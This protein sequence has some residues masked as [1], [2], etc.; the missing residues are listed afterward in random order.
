MGAKRPFPTVLEPLKDVQA[1][2][3]SLQSDGTW[4]ERGIGG[5]SVTQTCVTVVGEKNKVVA[6]HVLSTDNL[7]YPQA[8]GLQV[9]LDP[10][11]GVESVGSLMLCF[12]AASQAQAFLLE[13]AA[14]LDTFAADE[15]GGNGGS[16]GLFGSACVVGLR[17][18]SEDAAA[19]FERHTT[20]LVGDSPPEDP[21]CGDEAAAAAGGAAPPPLKR[22]RRSSSGPAVSPP[23]PSPA[24]CFPAAA[25]P[26]A[27]A[28]HAA[29]AAAATGGSADAYLV[30]P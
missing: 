28:A 21:D 23:P 3:H 13:L 2:V 22:A 8:D 16:R 12:R 5:L 17:R 19:S 27:A 4:L 24:G 29:A 1:K 11:H 9:R 25:G 7:Y 18:D 26:A 14:V 15:A 30:C 6:R 10:D 20:L